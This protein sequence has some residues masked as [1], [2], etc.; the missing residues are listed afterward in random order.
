MATVWRKGRKENMEPP[1][2]QQATKGTP[3]NICND[4]LVHSCF[5]R[6]ERKYFTFDLRANVRGK[7]VRITEEVN[8]RHD[9]IVVPLAGLAEFRDKL[10][11]MIE[12][13]KSMTDN[14]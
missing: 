8:G 10:N 7:F 12:A 13:S 6:A 2:A 14:T 1:Q 5:M 3:G 9:A 11:E 4:G